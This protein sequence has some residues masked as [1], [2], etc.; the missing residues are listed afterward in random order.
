MATLQV[1]YKKKTPITKQFTERIQERENMTG[2]KK[3]KEET[4]MSEAFFIVRIGWRVV[5]Y[6]GEKFSTH[7]HFEFYLLHLCHYYD[8]SWIM[9][10][11][12]DE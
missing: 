2:M 4:L 3:W 7:R 11:K 1:K 6:L 8:R 12:N 5:V 10:N 9:E